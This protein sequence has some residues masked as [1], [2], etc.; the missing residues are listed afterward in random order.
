MDLSNLNLLD[1]QSGYMQND[2]STIAMCT[3]LN[4]YFRELSEDLKLCLIYSRMDELAHFI[5]D[6]LAWQFSV[7]WYDVSEN[8]DV[9][10]NLIKNAL[11]IHMKKGTPKAVEDVISMYFGKGRVEEWFEYGGN[12]YM[13]KVI[14]NNTLITKTLADKF[15]DK[16]NKVKNLRSHL[17]EI[18]I[19]LEYSSVLTL[20][21][22][23]KKYEVHYLMCGEPLCGVE[24]ELQNTGL[25]KNLYMDLLSKYNLTEQNYRVPGT[26]LTTEG[27]MTIEN[28]G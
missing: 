22:S 17:E 1:L 19:Q 13:F 10:R 27:G 16:L 8:L 9:K 7:D 4:P 15:N 12:P 25:I 20:E 5:L 21:S 3:V 23:T 6:E 11:K 28:N 18:L 14:T 26:T 24:P 2:P